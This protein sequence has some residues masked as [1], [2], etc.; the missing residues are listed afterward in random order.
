MH[1]Q[2]VCPDGAG[3]SGCLIFWTGPDVTSAYNRISGRR[4]NRM[5]L[6]EG[7]NTSVVHV[8]PQTHRNL[9]DACSTSKT[10]AHSFIS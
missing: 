4:R 7:R 6:E 10:N 1:M 9:Q 8:P 3:T 2:I 5:L